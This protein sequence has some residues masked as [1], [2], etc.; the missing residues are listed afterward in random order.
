M[1]RADIHKD[2]IVKVAA[3]L[4]HLREKVVFIGG[5]IVPLLLTDEGAPDVRPT[6]DIDVIV[7]VISL[8]KFNL[9]EADLR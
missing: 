2:R 6:I 7:E 1:K 3:A 4:K 8:G 9:F 5:A